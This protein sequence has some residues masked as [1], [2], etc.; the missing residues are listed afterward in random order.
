MLKRGLLTE[1]GRPRL[2]AAAL[3]PEAGPVVQAAALG[4]V[5]KLLE[6]ERLTGAVVAGSDEERV[7]APSELASRQVL[8]MTIAADMAQ[9]P[10]AECR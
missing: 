4:L 2:Y 1:L 3:G 5:R 10:D 8:I 7:G 9:S 6:Q